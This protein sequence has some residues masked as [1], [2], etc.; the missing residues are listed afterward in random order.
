MQVIS[1]LLEIPTPQ[2]VYGMD[3][4]ADKTGAG[5]YIWITEAIPTD[6]GLLVENC[7]SAKDYL[8]LKT[9]R[10]EVVIPKLAECI[11]TSKSAVFG[12][13]F[14]FGLPIGLVK[15]STWRAFLEDFASRFATGDDFWAMTHE[16]SGG[17][18]LW[19]EVDKCAEAPMS[20]INWRM[21][22]QTF[23]GIH[24]VLFPLAT[25][26]EVNVPPLHFAEPEGT[27]VMEVCPASTLKHLDLYS[28]KKSQRLVR[29]R[30][31]SGLEGLGRVKF[32][33]EDLRKRV[34]ADNGCDALDSVIAA[35]AAWRAV[36]DPQ[37]ISNSMQ[38]P[39]TIEGFIYV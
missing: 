5:R 39:C 12:C 10:R 38:W 35:D 2:R 13:D 9:S 34:L 14:P 3:F 24:D 31:L 17:K 6:D 11:A 28:D 27:W 4:S 15:Q 20:P 36:R 22:M 32:E 23:H 25:K 18:D 8:G 37:R 29:E 16:E 30:F 26:H 7:Q 1:D 33:S 21:R 19:R